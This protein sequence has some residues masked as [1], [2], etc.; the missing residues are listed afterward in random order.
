MYK[1]CSSGNFLDRRQKL[2]KILVIWTGA[3]LEKVVLLRLSDVTH[4]LQD[5]LYEKDLDLGGGER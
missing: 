1:L 3:M 4:S 5:S 2:A